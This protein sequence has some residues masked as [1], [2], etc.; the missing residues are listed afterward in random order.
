MKEALTFPYRYGIDFVAELLTKG[1]KEKAFAGVFS[2]PP[3]TTRQIMEPKTYLSG[4]RVESMRLPDFKQ[5]FKDYD[6]FDIGAVGEF[7][8]A[9]LVDQYAGVEASQKLYPH[10][11]GGYYYAARPKG[12]PSAPL[13]LLYVSRWSNAERAAEFAAIYAKSLASRYQHV[14][15]V[16]GNGKKPAAALEM[17]ERL[18]GRH[19]WLT[20]EGPVVVDVD[21]DTVMVTETL[22]QST[23]ERLEEEILGAM[24]AGK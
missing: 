23:T 20:E 21:G 1:G 8:V 6:R 10:W 11:R 5:I 12:N 22:D 15:D 4:E 16:A 24:P 13:G 14:R 19:S 2:D 18:S 9:V 7:D 3:R 17:L